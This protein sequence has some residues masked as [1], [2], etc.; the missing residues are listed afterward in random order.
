MRTARSP[1]RAQPRVLLAHT[2]MPASVNEDEELVLHTLLH[3]LLREIGAWSCV[4][5]VHLPTF[6]LQ[7]VGRATWWTTLTDQCGHD[8]TAVGQF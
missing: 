1:T 7:S 4:A 6:S 2:L 5:A 3:Q 8:L